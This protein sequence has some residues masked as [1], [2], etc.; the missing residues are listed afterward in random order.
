MFQQEYLRQKKLKDEILKNID[1]LFENDSLFIL[2]FFFIFGLVK[3]M[4]LYSIRVYFCQTILK[5]LF[6]FS[7]SSLLS[8]CLALLLYMYFVK[9]RRFF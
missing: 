8:F 4:L 7:I 9:G 6:S 1:Y 2:I 5:A 3:E